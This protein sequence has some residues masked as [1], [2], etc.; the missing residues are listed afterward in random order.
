MKL[1]L[2]SFFQAV[3]YALDVTNYNG[4][5]LKVK[6]FKI[7]EACMLRKH[8]IGVLPTGYGKSVI[9]YLL[10]YVLDYL[11]DKG[12]KSIVIVISPLNALIDDQVASLKTRGIKAGVLRASRQEA[13]DVANDDGE[14]GLSEDE[15][16]V[17]M[18]KKYNYSISEADVFKY[19]QKGEFKVLFTHPEAFIS[20]K[21]GRKVFQSDLYQNRVVHCVIDEAHLIKEWGSEFRPD[22][23]K[24]AQPG[25][26]CPTAPTLA[27]TATAPQKLI[28]HLKVKLQIKNP[29]VLVGNLDR[30]NIFICKDKRRTS[31]SGAE[32]YNDILLPIAEKLKVELT[33]YP[34]TIIYLPLKWCGYAFKLFLNVLGEKS[35]A[36]Q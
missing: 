1:T 18:E 33:K 29:M 3:R 26:L 32:S 6:Q 12:N 23:G 16:E 11:N 22:F 21:D 19:V 5:F 13:F 17:T 20:C 15:N 4:V 35:Y 2:N 28:E 7:L 14:I 30:S 31:S 34:L 25:S 8:A 9:F 36:C 10:P 27:L 24:L